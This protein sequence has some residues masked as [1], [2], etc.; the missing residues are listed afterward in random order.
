MCTFDVY[1]MGKLLDR[2]FYCAGCTAEYVRDTLISRNG[3]PLAIVVLP[4]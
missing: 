1:F 3:Y 2:V 4:V